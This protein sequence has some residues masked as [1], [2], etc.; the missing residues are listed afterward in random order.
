MRTVSAIAFVLFAL[1]LVCGVAHAELRSL[2]W[3]SGVAESMESQESLAH[4]VY[5]QKQSD[6][7]KTFSRE[8]KVYGQ[9]Y[10]DVGNH[11]VSVVM[12]GEQ[13]ERFRTWDDEPESLVIISSVQFPMSSVPKEPGWFTVPLEL[14][15][16]PDYVYMGIFSRSKADFG[17]KIGRTAIDNVPSQ[18]CSAKPGNTDTDETAMMNIWEGG[19]WMMRLGVSP[20]PRE[21][22]PITSAELN[23]GFFEVLDDGEAEGFSVFQKG[24]PY[25]EVNNKRRKKVKRVYVYAQVDGDWYNTER[26]AAVFLLDSRRRIILKEELP[27]NRFSNVASWNYASFDGTRVPKDFYVLIEPFSR[28]GIEL[29]IG[30][31]LSGEN[32]GS[33]FGTV[34]AIYE[35]TLDLPEENTNWMI[36][37]EYE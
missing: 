14:V 5:F 23:G 28:P 20:T 33:V 35:W 3:D 22:K 1:M 10:G 34:G 16:M 2:K 15:D 32:Q 13:S 17:V 37:V 11:F 26:K 12:V 31:D 21:V 8:L 29:E 4:F 30:H 18:S 24:G 25:I 19:N 36:R 9:Q 6:W 27:Y 7:D